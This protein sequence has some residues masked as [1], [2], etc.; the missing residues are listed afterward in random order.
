MELEPEGV[1]P[2]G[3]SYFSENLYDDPDL[4]PEYCRYQDAD[5]CLSCPF[6]RCIY[7]EPGGKQ[8]FI[9]RLRN[10]EILRLYSGGKEIGELAVTFGISQRTVQRALKRAKQ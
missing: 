9:K 2:Q 8:H 5:S 1:I 3:N 10:Q 6:A 7:D 4:P